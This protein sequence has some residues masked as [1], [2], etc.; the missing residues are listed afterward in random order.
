MKEDFA[1]EKILDELRVLNEKS[2]DLED[3]RKDIRWGV[4]QGN[5]I[6]TLFWFGLGVVVAIITGGALLGL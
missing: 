3:L 4:F 1:V 6:T 5:L 2:L